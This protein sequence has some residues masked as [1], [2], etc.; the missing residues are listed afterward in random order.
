MQVLK[1]ASKFYKFCSTFKRKKLNVVFFFLFVLP[2]KEQKLM[3]TNGYKIKTLA[4]GYK[5]TE[6]KK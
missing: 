4:D 5:P 6:K 2:L 3:L 1:F